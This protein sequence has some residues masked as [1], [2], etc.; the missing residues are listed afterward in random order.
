MKI[1]S[2]TVIIPSDMLQK[3]F[4]LKGFIREAEQS[5]VYTSKPHRGKIFINALICLL[6]PNYI[7]KK[8]K[9]FFKK[10]CKNRAIT[11]VSQQAAVSTDANLLAKK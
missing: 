4:S 8:L 3:Y 6:F 7:Y 11:Y 1:H 9:K 10:K 5:K 2:H